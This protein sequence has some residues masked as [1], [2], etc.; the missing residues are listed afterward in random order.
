MAEGMADTLKQKVGPLPLWTWAVIGTGAVS[1]YLYRKNKANA[2]AQQQAPST[3]QSNLGNVPISNLSTSA[4][5]MPIQM[6][7]TFVNVSQ[8][9]DADNPGPAPGQPPG[10]KTP[11]P[12][13]APPPP[14]TKAPPPS[15][16]PTPPA[17]KT[18]TVTVCPYPAWCGSLYGI[19]QHEWGNGNLWPTIYNANKAKIGSNPNLIHVGTVLTIPAKPK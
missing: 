4:Q 11:T 7:D 16:K 17:P 3:D 14:V 13:K 6:G 1:F 10:V 18:T 12:V 8:P 5:P 19:A 2:A 9:P 15:P